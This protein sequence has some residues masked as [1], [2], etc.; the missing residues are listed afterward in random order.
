MAPGFRRWT[1]KT[2]ESCLSQMYSHH[3]LQWLADCHAQP[4]RMGR[5]TAKTS[6][7]FVRSV[8]SESVAA[9]RWPPTKGECCQV[10]ITFYVAARHKVGS[11]VI[12]RAEPSSFQDLTFVAQETQIVTAVAQKHLRSEIAVFCDAQISTCYLKTSCY[13][14][15]IFLGPFSMFAFFKST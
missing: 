14:S 8:K 15:D 2:S 6:V 13:K 11:K 5:R 1:A 7:Q 3:G 12:Q 9:C 10:M 4:L